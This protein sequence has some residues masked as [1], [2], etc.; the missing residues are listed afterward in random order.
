MG[1]RTVAVVL[2]AIAEMERWDGKHPSIVLDGDGAWKVYD[3]DELLPEP[4]PELLAKVRQVEES[5]YAAG[6][7]RSRKRSQSCLYCG[8]KILVT[9]VAWVVNG[10]PELECRACRE[11]DED[12]E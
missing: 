10:G 8:K 4:S 2:R 3:P 5:L 12:D 7:A 11:R 9:D 6:V 1:K